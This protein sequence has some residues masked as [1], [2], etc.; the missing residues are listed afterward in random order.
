MHLKPR[1]V[2]MHVLVRT[3]AIWQ[4]CMPRPVDL[5]TCVALLDRIIPSMIPC[6]LIAQKPRAISQVHTESS[7]ESSPKSSPGFITSQQD[8]G[9]VKEIFV[10]FNNRIHSIINRSTSL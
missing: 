4:F 9:L 7:P 6:K 8:G 3:D 10:S 1:C 2:I 5:H